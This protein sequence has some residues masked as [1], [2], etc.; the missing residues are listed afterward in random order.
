[1]YK[2]QGNNNDNQYQFLADLNLDG[3]DEI[4]LGQNTV[5]AD[6]RH[7]G[8]HIF[9]SVTGQE[10]TRNW[11]DNDFLDSYKIASI[12]VNTIKILVAMNLLV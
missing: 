5:P 1:M 2:R 12:S 7:F 4:I 9:N 6:N 11:F 10:E 8:I 3:V